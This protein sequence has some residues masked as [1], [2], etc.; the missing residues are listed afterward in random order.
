MIG[1]I[2]I[3]PRA[4]PP[5]WIRLGV[6]IGSLLA[7]AVVGG[8]II[9]IA[10]NNPIEAYETMIDASLNG[11]RSITRTLTLATPLILTVLAA[12][13]TFRMR[14][15]NIGAEGQLYIGAIAASGL[16]IALPADTPKPIMLLAILVGGSVAGA[17]WAGLAAVPKA[18]LN[19]DEVIT[20]LMLNFVA[21]SFM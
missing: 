9:A 11:V 18:Y 17:G 8:A 7:A 15:W 21:L 14:I 19:T 1:G 13:V 6:P 12:A 20:T 16:A 10:G 5:W 4:R 2:T 3:E